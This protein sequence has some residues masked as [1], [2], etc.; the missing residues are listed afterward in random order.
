MLAH[1]L[2]Q[3]NLLQ[4]ILKPRISKP[5]SNHTCCT[6]KPWQC[7][8][9]SLLMYHTSCLLTVLFLIEMFLSSNFAPAKANHNV[10]FVQIILGIS[11]DWDSDMYT[12]FYY[13]IGYCL[14]PDSLPDLPSISMDGLAILETANFL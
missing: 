14:I 6:P 7:L 11:Y 5:H 3:L 9:K 10:L 2:P 13:I 12:L 8:P 4:S 1:G